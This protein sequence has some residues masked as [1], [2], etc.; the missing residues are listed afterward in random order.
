MTSP[1]KD[2]V[3]PAGA[4]DVE[5]DALDA[6]TG[7]AFYYKMNTISDTSLQTTGITDGTSNTLLGDGSVRTLDT[8]A[9]KL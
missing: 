7:G 5:E 4:V 6:A 9:V 3:T 1:N 2:Q 8:Y